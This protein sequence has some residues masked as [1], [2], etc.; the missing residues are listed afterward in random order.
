MDLLEVWVVL[1]EPA[2]ATL[3]ADAT[4][5][6]A[7]RQRIIVKQQDEVMARIVALGGTES[8]RVQQVSNALAVRV[9]ASALSSVKN[10][11]G[12]TSVYRVSHRNPH[13]RLAL[14]PVDDLPKRRAV[15]VA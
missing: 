11:L 13:R 8:G 14:L 2:L 7:E 12:V 1:S 4:E 3:P 6:R 10:I 5:Q 15:S 9:P